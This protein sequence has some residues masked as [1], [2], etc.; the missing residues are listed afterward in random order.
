MAFASAIEETQFDIAYVA[1][2]CPL[3]NAWNKGRAYDPGN[4]ATMQI[5]RIKRATINAGDRNIE[6]EWTPS[7]QDDPVKDLVHPIFAMGS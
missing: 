6:V 3:V 5:A 7:H 2:H 4:G 1:D